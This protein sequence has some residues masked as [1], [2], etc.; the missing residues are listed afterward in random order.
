[1]SRV[2][3]SYIFSL[4]RISIPRSIKFKN[5]PAKIF[6][7]CDG[8]EARGPSQRIFLSG[9]PNVV[10]VHGDDVIVGMMTGFIKLWKPNDPDPQVP[11]LFLVRGY[12]AHKFLTLTN[13]GCQIFHGTKY[14]NGKKYTELPQTIP[15]VHKIYQKTVKRTKCP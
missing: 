11:D 9:L 2:H 14:Q 13:Q 5:F 8:D 1:L 7:L 10:L 4:V 15:N 12:Q 6:R 3:F